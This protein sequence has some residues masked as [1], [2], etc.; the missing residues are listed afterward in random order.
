ME[1]AEFLEA[2]VKAATRIGR[3]ELIGA[4]HDAHDLEETVA[5]E[6]DRAETR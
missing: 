1:N 3:E 5:S 2:Y 4:W 6:P